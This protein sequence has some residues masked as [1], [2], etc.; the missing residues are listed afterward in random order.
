M[1]LV[2]LDICEWL[3]IKNRIIDFDTILRLS[4]PNSTQKLAYWGGLSNYL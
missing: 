2:G 1:K 4:E 3:N